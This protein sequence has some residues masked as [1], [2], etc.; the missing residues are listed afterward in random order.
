MIEVEIDREI[1]HE[2]HHPICRK[3]DHPIDHLI[4]CEIDHKINRPIDTSSPALP[5][6]VKPE[7]LGLR[8]N[9]PQ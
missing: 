5:S 3:I 7:F 6:P 2:S 4:D 1:K 9:N 8:H